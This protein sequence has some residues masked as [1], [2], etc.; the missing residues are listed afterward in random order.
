[1]DVCFSCLSRSVF[2][3][4][5]RAADQ[6][7]IRSHGLCSGQRQCCNTLQNRTSHQGKVNC[8]HSHADRS[9]ASSIHLLP[10]P[11]RVDVIACAAALGSVP[12]STSSAAAR[13][14]LPGTSLRLLSHSRNRRFSHIVKDW[15][16]GFFCLYKQFSDPCQK[17]K[18]KSEF[19]IT[20][21]RRAGNL[22]RDARRSVVGHVSKANDGAASCCIVLL[23]TA[24]RINTRINNRN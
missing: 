21:E 1:M 12:P 3:A 24:A 4:V 9:T 19:P 15:L 14:L 2:P 18:K 17:K 16:Y 8:D 13:L 11:V 23:S 5:N 6:G 20:E 10:P 7:L 22:Q